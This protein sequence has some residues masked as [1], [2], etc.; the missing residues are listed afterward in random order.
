MKTACS[1]TSKVSVTPNADGRTFKRAV[2]RQR[3]RLLPEDSGIIQFDLIFKATKWGV[4][5]TFL[6]GGV[7]VDQM[8]QY[9]APAPSALL[10]PRS[11]ARPTPSAIPAS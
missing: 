6:V 11:P 8:Q 4:K 10:M 9:N 2:R 7:F 3:L 5:N 1:T